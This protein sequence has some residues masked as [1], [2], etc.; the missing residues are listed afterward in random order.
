MTDKKNDILTD[1]EGFCGQTLDILTVLDLAGLELDSAN[2]T[3]IINTCYHALKQL[4]SEH[5]ELT[6]E[7]R[8][9]L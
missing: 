3:A 5:T 8:K 1:Y 6:Y 7:Y 4:I 9:N 2:K